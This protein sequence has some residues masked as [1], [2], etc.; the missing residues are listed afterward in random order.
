MILYLNMFYK[1]KS[2][3]K[4]KYEWQIEKIYLNVVSKT[5]DR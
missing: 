5:R 4:L 2:G 3:L 1:L